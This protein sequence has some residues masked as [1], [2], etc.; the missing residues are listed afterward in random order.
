VN[1]NVGFH[2]HRHFNNISACLKVYRTNLL[3]RSLS[4]MS[5]DVKL[6]ILH[7]YTISNS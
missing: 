6:I 7:K 3:T 5:R 1:S 2:H 4:S